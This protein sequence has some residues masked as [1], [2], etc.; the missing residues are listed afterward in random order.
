[1][2]LNQNKLSELNEIAIPIFAKFLTR[3]ETELFLDVKINC[4]YD[5]YADSVELHKI[6][7][8]NPLYNFH[9]FG[10]AVDLN[11][12]KDGRTYRKNDIIDDWCRT[13]VPQLA[14]DMNIRWGGLFSG[15]PDCVHF[16]LA[17][18]FGGNIFEVLNKF[19]NLANGNFN[20]SNKLDLSKLFVS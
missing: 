8:R 5:S 13:G 10:I 12:I 16:D 4:V 17:N 18:Y 7:I 1:M 19:I 2:I 14:K 9:E 11:V 15:Y 6:D 20:E 3:I